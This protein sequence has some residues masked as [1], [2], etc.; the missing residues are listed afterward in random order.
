MSLS[1]LLVSLALSNAAPPPEMRV[2]VADLDFARTE[3][4]ATFRNRLSD[5]AG[6]FCDQHRALITPSHVRAGGWCERTVSA[7][8]VSRL[9]ADARR[10]LR[11]DGPVVRRQRPA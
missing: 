5:A 8:A 11:R 7:E 9:P 6:D 3:D 4:R 1:A 2:A 10:E